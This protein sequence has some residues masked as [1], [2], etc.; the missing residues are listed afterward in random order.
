M[1]EWFNLLAWKAGVRQRTEGSNPSLSTT[2]IKP[3]NVAIY[4]LLKAIFDKTCVQ[5]MCTI[6]LKYHPC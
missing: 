3:F 1:S 6:M 4:S 5:S 2:Y